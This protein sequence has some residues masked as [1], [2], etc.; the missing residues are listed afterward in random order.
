MSATPTEPSAFKDQLDQMSQNL[1]A[2][3][4]RAAT[5]AELNRLLAQ[6]RDPIE[7]AQRAVDLVMRATGAA[8][9]FVYLWDPEA[10]RLVMRVA[11]TGR[12]AAHVD[13]IQLR[14]GEG[15]TGWTG[16][17]RQTVV[18][19]DDIQKDPRFASFPVLE[20]DRFRS[21]VAVPIAV[22]GSDLLGVFSLW[23]TEP[24]AFDSHHVDLA[25][26]VGGLLASGLVQAHTVEDLKRQSAAARFLTTVPADVT[27]SLQRCVDVLAESVREQVDAAL[28]TIELADRGALDAPVR[29]GISFADG[30]DVALAIAA[31]QV[32]SRADLGELIQRLGPEQY[33]FT[34]SFGA[35]FPLGALSCYRRRPFSDTDANIIEALGA[36]SAALIA[37]LSNPAMVTPLVGRLASASTSEHAER[38][39][40]DLG[41]RP[42][43]THPVLVRLRSRQYTAPAEFDRVLSALRELCR[44]FD[45]TVIAPA[46]PSVTLLIRHQQDQWKGFEQ[47]LR[48][49]LRSVRFRAAQGLSAG[50]GRLAGSVDEVV[51]GLEMAESALTWAELVGADGPVVVHYDDIAHL[52]MLPS[53]AL[54]SGDSLRDALAHFET[55]IRYDQRHGTDL[56]K[57]LD[58]YL[59]N[60]C[61]I[62]DTA[63]ELFIHRNTLRQRLG[64][65][66]DLTGHT[67]EQLGDWTVVA[68]AARLAALSGGRLRTVR[69]REAN[70]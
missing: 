8:G 51:A 13:K 10:Q 52:R 2:T 25:S 14:L 17:M 48:N 59:A 40:C 61:S 42:G 36:Q 1:V 65:I 56:S 11:T 15:I 7:F 55:I 44:P 46:P 3:Q 34:T 41:W 12:Q 47:N 22:P 4:R 32:R 67:A 69:G 19:Q 29:P 68:L 70:G 33:K 38:I 57:T 63:A 5:L 58:S 49:T 50:I 45:G 21:M 9:T 26:E 6:G 64:R 30:V 18:L 66:E 53:V 20:E 54:E 23:A 35:L 60:R 31:R 24:E 43:S 37:S 27:S 62:T 16:L 28:C 39:L